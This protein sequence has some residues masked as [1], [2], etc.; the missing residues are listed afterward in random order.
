MKKQITNQTIV[1]TDNYPSL[2]DGGGGNAPRRRTNKHSIFLKNGMFTGFLLLLAVLFLP[3]AARAVTPDPNSFPFNGKGFTPYSSAAFNSSRADMLI[4]FY[5]DVGSD[6]Y[7]RSDLTTYSNLEFYNGTSWTKILEFR[8]KDQKEANWYW[9]DVRKVSSSV[10]S[11]KGYSN[12]DGRG[13]VQ[14]GTE[15]T[16]IKVYRSIISTHSCTYLELMID[17]NSSTFGTQ[18]VAFR[19]NAYWHQN[20]NGNYSGTWYLNNKQDPF[21]VWHAGNSMHAPTVSS[22]TIESDGRIT[23][24]AS[25]NS[26]VEYDD[27]GTVKNNGYY[28][29][30]NVKI[31]NA[32]PQAETKY[33]C[34]SSTAFG[35]ITL[36]ARNRAYFNSSHIIY[37]DNGRYDM[38]PPY[39]SILSSGYSVPAYPCPSGLTASANN[40]E[41]K[42]QW[43]M[44]AGTSSSAVDNYQIKWRKGTGAWQTVNVTKAY[45]YSETNPSVTF[46]CPEVD[47]GTND[48]YFLVARGKFA[49]DNSNYNAISSKVNIATNKILPTAINANLQS[50]N[51]IKVTW[52]TDGGRTGSAFRYRLYRKAGNNSYELLTTVTT[53]IK[54]YI[55]NS[56]AACTSYLY[57]VRAYDGSNEY[58][59]KATTAAIVR[60]AGNVGEISD[61]SV[62]K[63]FYND[64]VNITW[65]VSSGAGFTRFSIMKKIQNM[66]NA[67]EQQIYEVASSGLLQYSFDDVNATAGTYY[68]YRVVAWTECNG[69]ANEGGS[70]VSTGFK[71]PYGIASGKVSYANDIAVE[72]VSVMAVGE[73]DYANRGLE[74]INAS[75]TYIQTPYK[76]GTLSNSAFTFQAWV[77]FGNQNNS[78]YDN[79]L[80]EAGGKYGLCINGSSNIVLR[81]YRGS[82]STD[83]YTFTV[84][85]Q[86]HIFIHISVTY[87]CSGTTGTAVLYING[88][89]VQTLV[90]SD[91]QVWTFP[92]GSAAYYNNIYFGSNLTLNNLYNMNGYMDE[93]RLWNR[94]ITA[95]EIKN[96]YNAY[97]SGKEDGLKL[98]YRL[99]EQTGDEIFDISKQNGVFNENHGALIYNGGI[100]MHSDVVPTTEQLSIR[101]VT[102]SN[103]AYILNTIPY[104]GDGSMFTI[105]PSLPNHNFNP[106]NKPLYFNQQSASYSN[107]NFTDISSFMVR[108]QVE[109]E[110]GSYP[111]ADC[112]FEV[113]GQILTMSNGTV[114]K[115]ENNGNF[116][117]SVPIGVH[118]VRVVKQGHTFAN[119]GY[120]KD[121]DSLNLNYNAPLANIRFKDQTKVKFIGRVVGGNTEDGK[122]LGFGESVNNIGVDSIVLNTTNLAYNFSETPVSAT[123]YHNNGQ[124]KKSG[125]LSDDSTRVDYNQ[126]D[127]IIHVSPQTGEFSAMVYPEPYNIQPISVTQGYGKSVL[128]VKENAENIDL[129]ATAVPDASYLQAEIRTWAD[130]TFVTNRPGVVDHWEYSEQ[131]DTVRYNSKWT[132]KYQATPT[133]GVKQIDNG[134]AVDYFGEKTFELKDE[135]QGIN[136]NIALFNENDSTYMFGKPVFQQGNKY[137][138]RFNAYEEYTNYVSNP[139]V[140]VTY[141]VSNGTVNL[142]NNLQVTPQPE[143]LEMDSAGILNYSF[144]AGAPNL[145]TASGDIFATLALGA[146]SYYWNMGT[147]PLEAWQIGEDGKG[148][149]FMTSGP[150]QLTAILRDP[151]GSGSYAYFESGKT[152]TSTSKLSAGATLTEELNLTTS[153]GANVTTF[154]GLGAG[155]IT[156]VGT[157]ADLA[158]NI[159]SEQTYSYENE[160]SITTTFNERFQTSSSTDFVGAPGDVF[161][162][163]RQI[164]SMV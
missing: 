25:I 105:V 23:V 75:K 135:I 96:N 154:V 65:K 102:D 51:T 107:V 140:T 136:E 158:T 90:K 131:S 74:F 1:E 92:T 39:S 122:P 79:Y 83:N 110:G 35:S 19:V 91:T 60:P 18:P 100:N 71:Q 120:L 6:R 153:L 24:A 161:I 63:G 30:K 141:P 57:E 38:Q 112:S 156:E 126:K 149:N 22:Y 40:G 9:I 31:D 89:P 3:A 41:I 44:T 69:V 13:M 87:Q 129:T 144:M 56:V 48:Y 160:C 15:W 93:I 143:S 64:R 55:D 42:L 10:P 4:P 125:G 49:Y 7:L 108:G 123:Y 159:S 17:Y 148:N 104:T 163:T 14:I 8:C 11:T 66:P 16:T 155:V 162:A 157:K 78:V 33:D 37:A 117:I 29:A 145:T 28:N 124:W 81:V 61:L 27:K 151:P 82:T 77:N 26:Y 34:T 88:E 109:Y 43:N 152:I 138:L 32:Y 150:D 111:V 2:K 121:A 53:D 85:V 115:S 50:N 73:S 52:G 134:Q 62:S 98:Y 113:D 97:I 101:T 95:T 86:R 5:D 46:P 119:G 116:E 72:G 99:D 84:P 132:F 142:T 127:I 67:A 68:D 133:F 137:D 76:T 118:S 47:A 58:A 164:L 139:T 70:L 45:S 146:V 130:S 36:P 114:V 54:E 94:D 12:Q 147:T 106:T 80:F 20:D 128:I 103:G 21:E 59:S